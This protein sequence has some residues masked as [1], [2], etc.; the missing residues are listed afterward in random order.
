MPVSPKIPGMH[1][2]ENIHRANGSKWEH[3]SGALFVKGWCWIRTSDLCL[4]VT[5]SCVGFLTYAAFQSVTLGWAFWVVCLG[6]LCLGFAAI[7]QWFPWPL[8]P[9]PGRAY[10]GI[11]KRSREL[12]QTPHKLSTLRR[13]VSSLSRSRHA[14]LWW[15]LNAGK[16]S[17]RIFGLCVDDKSQWQDLIWYT[18]V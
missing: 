4:A 2:C 8:T 18:R 16:E 13:R 5:M 10:P 17:S 3:V 11:E 9:D 15:S 14:S 1:C 12:S 6:S 7:C